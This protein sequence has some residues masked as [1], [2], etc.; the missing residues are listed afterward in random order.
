MRE[1]PAYIPKRGEFFAHDDR[2]ADGDVG[3][4]GEGWGEAREAEGEDK[5]VGRWRADALAPSGEESV[6]TRDKG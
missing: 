2:G 3:D 5:L 1:N 6:G 4:G